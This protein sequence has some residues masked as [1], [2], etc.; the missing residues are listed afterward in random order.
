MILYVLDPDAAS[1]EGLSPVTACSVQALHQLE[2]F[3]HQVVFPL[4]IHA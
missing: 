1:G 2:S 4:V 3:V